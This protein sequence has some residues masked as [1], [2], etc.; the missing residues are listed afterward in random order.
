[1]FRLIAPPRPRAALAAL[2][3]LAALSSFLLLA[4]CGMTTAADWKRCDFEVTE[5]SFR[6]F[7][8]DNALWRVSVAAANPNARKLRLDGLHLWAVM[9]GDTLARLANPGRIEL[10]ARDTTRLALDVSLPPEAWNKALARLRRAGKG[11]VLI[12]GDVEAPTLF[13]TRRIRN[14]VHEKQS[15]DLGGILGSGDFLRSLFGR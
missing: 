14:A 2:P 10:A 7:R 3:L 8:D 13:G 4:G 15:I 6:G 1:M 9:E 5:L 12:T 11:E